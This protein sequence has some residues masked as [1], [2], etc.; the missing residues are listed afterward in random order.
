MM[1]NIAG[2]RAFSGG[3]GEKVERKHASVTIRKSRNK[4]PEGPVVTLEELLQARILEGDLQVE[5]D[6][7]IVPLGHLDKLYWPG[8]AI[9]KGDLIK[10]YAQVS[11]HIIPYLRNRPLILKRYPNGINAPFF[12]Q[13]ELENAPA[14]VH[15]E[16]L[17]V[18]T[19]RQ[20][21][22]AVIDNLATL[23]YLTN[24]G[25]IEEHPWNSRLLDLDHPDWVVFDLDPG[26]A[27]F[28]MVCLVA[29][30]VR[31]VLAALDLPSYPKTSGSRGIHVF[32]PIEPKYSYDVVARFAERVAAI[33]V[34]ENPKIATIERSLKKRKSDL[35]YVDHMQ[36]ARG[37][38]IAAPYSARAR[39]AAT[40]S[41]PLTWKEVKSRVTPAD[42]TIKTVPKRL[43]KRGD[44]FKPVLE[45]K[46]SLDDAMKRLELVAK[47]RLKLVR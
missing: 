11:E 2:A 27:E 40:V 41:T 25:T 7:T 44:L 32:L 46:C 33:L 38:S 3:A 39:P 26:N 18:E 13:H 42:F 31:D 20:I 35:V 45:E 34:N 19:G 37:K 29:R 43:A 1:A 30:S 10:Y 6:N 15:T 28:E 16:R 8:E 36:N 24:L 5:V 14:F 12:F 9:T 47:P 4:K 21:D 22:Y 23:L 17:E